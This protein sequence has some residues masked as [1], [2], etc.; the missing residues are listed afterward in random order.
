MNPTE[1]SVDR[2]EIPVSRTWDL[3]TLYDSR[4]EW[5]D[6][7]E[8]AAE[9]VSELEVEP[10]LL[11]DGRTLSEFLTRFESIMRDVESV[12]KYA[13]M[14]RD[15]NL[16][17]DEYARLLGRSRSV[18]SA[19]NTVNAEIERVIASAGEER[20]DRLVDRSPELAH[21]EHYLRDVCR[22]SAGT[23]V[24]STLDA[25]E[26]ALSAPRDL[27]RTATRSMLDPP[28]ITVDG[29][30]KS[31]TATNFMRFQRHPDRDVR[32]RSY[33]A[34]YE[35]LADVEEVVASA[36][37]SHFETQAGRA[38]ARGF[39]SARSERLHEADVPV[40]LHERLLSEI[41]DSADRLHDHLRRQRNLLD[42]ERLRPWDVHARVWSRRQT[43]PYEVAKSHLIDAS[44]RLGERYRDAVASIL[45]S[46]RVDVHARRGKRSRAYT[47]TVYGDGSFVL[48]N[49]QNDVHSA[50]TLAHEVGHAVQARFATDE[51]S[52]LHADHPDPV[53]E[54]PSTVLEVLFG[55]QLVD[56]AESASLRNAAREE[57][58]DRLRNK[59]YRHALFATFDHRCQQRVPERDFVRAETFYDIYGDLFETF[60]EPVTTHENVELGW[61]R[62]PSFPSPYD[63]YK[64]CLGATVAVSVVTDVFDG[65]VEPF[66]DF[67]ERGGSTGPVAL[68]DGLGANP[69]DCD[70][71]E[72]AARTYG[73]LVADLS[74]D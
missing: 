49:Y 23:T 40:A 17:D 64:Y 60:Y 32:E 21:Y 56:A 53:S 58:A 11:E 2:N 71:V 13:R 4:D 26:P 73:E 8:S 70:V 65:R 29:E 62:R 37:R 42:L 36:Y 30:S 50:F 20:M 35:S 19:A 59:I 47:R 52:F 34:L 72:T 10:R 57:Y 6:A 27:Y 41:R 55:R 24:E 5:E 45:D 7:L 1:S 31:T 18:V 12:A 38:R 43:V 61:L 74:A 14:Q 63:A 48:L 28:E 16:G 46:R 22:C 44:S 54:V 69:L 66:L 39:E 68:L 3:T 9:R 25:L 51:Q 33:H 67:L 15:A